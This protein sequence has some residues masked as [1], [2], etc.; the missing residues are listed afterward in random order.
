MRSN[1]KIHSL[2]PKSVF[3]LLALVPMVAS[4]QWRIG[5][6]VGASCNHFVIDKQ[7]QTDYQ[8]KDRWGMT[9]SLTG[10]Y[11]FKD[12]LAVRAE[13]NW[14]QKNH[15][16]TRYQ[17]SQLN[18]RY[19]NNYLQLPV[20]ASFSF[21][22]Q[23]LRGFC[24]LGVYAGYWLSSRREG[25]DYNSFTGKPYIIREDV[26]FNSDRD[27]RMDAGL[28]GGL[29]MEYRIARHWVAQVEVRYYYSTVSTQKDY[30]RVK[31]PRY[32][33]TLALQLG[34]SYLF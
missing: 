16:Q 34:G 26:K 6:Q 19:F 9:V 7:Y 30:M 14:T 29:G 17:L 1:R 20:M 25:T 13:L 22:G 10:Q 33:S 24:N 15:R 5:A 18:Y 8:Y 28:L 3:L 11:D 4:A 31:D 2:I 23:K 21:G 12:W 32:N 27:Q